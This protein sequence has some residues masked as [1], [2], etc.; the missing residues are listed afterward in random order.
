MLLRDLLDGELE[1][2]HLQDLAGSKT[3]SPPFQAPAR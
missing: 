2:S 3:S 1:P